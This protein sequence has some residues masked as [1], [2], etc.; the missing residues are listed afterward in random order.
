MSIAGSGTWQAPG[1]LLI[2]PCRFVCRNLRYVRRGVCLAFTG[3]RCDGKG[4]RKREFEESDR[5]AGVALGK[6]GSG[7]GRQDTA[8]EGRL[9]KVGMKER[10]R[11]RIKGPFRAD[12]IDSYAMSCAGLTQQPSNLCCSASDEEETTL[13]AKRNETTPRIEDE[14]TLRR[15]K[16]FWNGGWTEDGWGNKQGYARVQHNLE[17]SLDGFAHGSTRGR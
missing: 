7:A 12:K 2:F 13:A 16:G 14:R 15:K 6:E 10:D 17:R 4:G 8:K 11:I 5:R 3:K 1:D 9:G